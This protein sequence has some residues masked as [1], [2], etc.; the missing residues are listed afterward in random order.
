FRQRSR[1]EDFLKACECD[2]RGRLGLDRCP[3]EDAEHLSRALQAALTVDA[4]AIAKQCQSPVQIKQ[5]V[6][7][8]RT[9]A[10]QQAM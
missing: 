7:E 8:A 9:Q 1:F 6:A 2:S 5:A 3:L 4:G 10:I